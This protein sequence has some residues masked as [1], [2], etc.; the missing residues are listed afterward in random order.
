MY[1]ILLSILHVPAQTALNTKPYP[2]QVHYYDNTLS[3]T[4]CYPNNYKTTPTAAMATLPPNNKA[5]PTTVMTTH[6][7][8]GVTRDQAMVLVHHGPATILHLLQVLQETSILIPVQ[9]RQGSLVILVL[10][11]EM[12]PAGLWLL[13]RVIFSIDI[14]HL[15][16]GLTGLTPQLSLGLGSLPGE[17]GRERSKQTLPTCTVH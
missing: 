7:H 9:G 1:R 8:G 2:L 16:P 6:V 13:I 14:H 10:P 12:T 3:H 17:R 4:H 5:T 15:L 11:G